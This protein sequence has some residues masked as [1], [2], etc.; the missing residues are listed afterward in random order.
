MNTDSMSEVPVGWVETPLRAVTTISDFGFRTSFGLRP[1]DF[2]FPATWLL[3]LLLTILTPYPVKGDGGLVQL[4]ESQ[5]PFS[6]TVFA[7]PETTRDGL[8]DVSV[9]VQWKQNG[10]VVLDAD[11][12]LTLES[13]KSLATDRSDPLCGVSRPASA[14]QSADMTEPPTSVPA[15]H[16]KASNKL[17]YAASLK[18]TSTGLRRVYV[19]VARGAESARFDCPL[20][21]P[22][23]S[24][25]L[26][27]LWPCLAFPP[28]A[29]MAFAINQWLRRESLQKGLERHS[30]PSLI[31][32]QSR[33][34]IERTSKFCF[35]KL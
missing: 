23:T 26:A 30:T 4:R 16:E 24:A 3:A 15:T 20:P 11:V 10:D 12:I 29:I 14:I 5:G 21:V 13:P 28:I 2:G 27:A 7:S 17:L 31:H 22:Q 6:V 19:S 35:A 9:L 32:A 33:A 8:T 34:R 25:K 18:L 1:S